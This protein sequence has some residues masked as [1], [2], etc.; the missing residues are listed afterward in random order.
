MTVLWKKTITTKENGTFDIQCEDW[1]KDYPDTFTYGSMLAAYPKS[2]ASVEG[3]F[4]PRRGRTFRCAFHFGNNSDVEE[5]MRKLENGETE[6]A[7]Y[8]QYLENSK[9]LV[10]LTGA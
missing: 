5:A 7:D 8:E 9:Y 1:S 4:A 3:Y 10:C 6:L 2:K